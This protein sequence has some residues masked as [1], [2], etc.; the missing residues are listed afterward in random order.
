MT[1][2]FP[3]QYF[4]GLSGLKQGGWDLQATELRCGATHCSGTIMLYGAGQWGAPSGQGPNGEGNG[5]QVY[6]QYAPPSGPL[7]LE[8]QMPPYEPA[9]EAVLNANF[10]SS[11]AC[12]ACA[13]V[14][15]GLGYGRVWTRED[16]TN[17]WQPTTI[18]NNTTGASVQVRSLF[19]YTDSQTGVSYLFA[20]SD[21]TN[22]PGGHFSCDLQ[23]QRVRQPSVG[24]DAGTRNLCNQ[25]WSVLHRALRPPHCLVGG[26]WGLRRRARRQHGSHGRRWF[27][28]C[29]L[30]DHG[31][32]DRHTG[33]DRKLYNQSGADRP[34]R[35]RSYDPRNGS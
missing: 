25:Q 28:P 23:R 31:A 7:A 2:A 22:W 12:K 10:P 4:L 20:G 6:A 17:S 3:N 26:Y 16:T 11:G 32:D 29:R 21:D 19:A 35:T 33:W 13:A 24:L 27:S 18:W 14:D 1:L 30:H 15:N 34:Y 5:A 8:C 9:V